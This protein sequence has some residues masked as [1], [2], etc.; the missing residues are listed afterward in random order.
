MQIQGETLLNLKGLKRTPIRLGDRTVGSYHAITNWLAVGERTSSFKTQIGLFGGLALCYLFFAWLS[1]VNLSI[2]IIACSTLLA[3]VAILLPRQALLLL[4]FCAP[5]QEIFSL[6]REDTQIILAAGIMTLFARIAPLL[7]KLFVRSASILYTLGLFVTWCIAR[8]LVDCSGLTVAELLQQSKAVVFFTCLL[9]IGLFAFKSIDDPL[10]KGVIVPVFSIVIFIIIFDGVVTYFPDVTE[11]LQLTP[12]VYEPDLR[13]AG[14]HLNPNAT[15]KFVAL[16]ILCTAASFWVQ[17]K[18]RKYVRFASAIA[19]MVLAM[20]LGATASKAVILGIFAAL[21]VFVA[22]TF[23]QRRWQELGGA[24]YT[25]VLIAG[26]LAIWY[27]TI[28]P[29]FHEQAVQRWAA[30]SQQEPKIIE[31]EAEG[32]FLSRLEH[33]LRMSESYMMKVAP[34]GLAPGKK[35]EIYKNIEGSIVY[36]KRD[37]GWLCTGQRDLLWGTGLSIVKEHWFLGIGPTGWPREYYARLGFPFDSP[38]NAILEMWGSYGLVGLGLYLLLVVQIVL[39]V[40]RAFQSTHV[41]VRKLL[42]E[43]TAL[44]GIVILFTELVEPAKFLS[45]SPHAVWIWLLLPI[46]AKLLGTRP[47]L[48]GF[49]PISVREYLTRA[50][51]LVRGVPIRRPP[52]RDFK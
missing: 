4:L 26:A 13:L 6:R 24:C 43:S 47:L 28:A 38:H 46:Q 1:R 45:M 16:G 19:L 52:W 41:S 14:L 31:T 36:T 23:A 18:T 49:Y 21:S 42:V 50:G 17:L 33:E 25:M 37:C 51:R 2:S 11:I 15:A 44:F 8:E 12:A 35:S 7:P 30:V 29:V 3:V 5:I 20:A 32:S 48:Q 27:L 22:T 9:G 34:E 40:M 10:T 39:Q